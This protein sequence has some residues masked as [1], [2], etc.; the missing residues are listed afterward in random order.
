MQSAY[1]MCAAFVKIP[2]NARLFRIMKG[3]ACCYDAGP[4]FI[5]GAGCYGA[6]CCS[7]KLL[8]GGEVPLS[9]SLI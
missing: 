3:G 6:G 8:D 5:G 9:V 2:R 4:D 1:F 7:G